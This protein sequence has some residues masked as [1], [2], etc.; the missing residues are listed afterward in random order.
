MKVRAIIGPENFEEDAGNACD[1]CWF[2]YQE[3]NE[4]AR[5]CPCQ[6]PTCSLMWC[7][8]HPT[9]PQ[10]RHSARRL[11]LAGLVSDQL[12]QT[13]PI[14]DSLAEMLE[15]EFTAYRRALEIAR[16]THWLDGAPLMENEGR[17]KTNWFKNEAPDWAYKDSPTHPETQMDLLEGTTN[18][19]GAP[20]P[21]RTSEDQT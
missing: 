1:A 5:K 11:H 17:W 4:N 6:N 12:I 15:A 10:D 20:T 8:G 9:Q 21:G 2:Q 19:G 16:G 14:P 13:Y 7:G 18:R 3:I